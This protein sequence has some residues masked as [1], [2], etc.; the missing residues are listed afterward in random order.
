MSMA[1][2]VEYAVIMVC[3][4]L[5]VFN[6]RILHSTT[7]F[8]QTKSS[9]IE[10]S[11]SIMH[12]IFHECV[13][14]F[15]PL[16]WRVK[17]TQNEL[18]QRNTKLLFVLRRCSKTVHYTTGVSWMRRGGILMGKPPVPRAQTLPQTGGGQNA[19]GDVA[20]AIKVEADRR[21]EG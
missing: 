20:N 11:L 16:S 14:C 7:N 21:G 5:V 10:I 15:F 19:M 4:P 9:G 17:E 1:L 3:Q 2:R 13:S 8:E 6:E 18:Q 12:R